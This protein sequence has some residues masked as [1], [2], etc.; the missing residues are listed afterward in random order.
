M[1]VL[2]PRFLARWAIVVAALS[3]SGCKEAEQVQADHAA[4][5]KRQAD[6]KV[7]FDGLEQKLMDLRKAVPPGATP[8]DSARRMTT[9]LQT[10]LEVLDHQLEVATKDF[11]AAD[12]ELNSLREQLG[13]MKKEL[14]R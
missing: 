13:Q 1:N 10:E 3:L 7:E 14:D 4:T 11:E 5:L 9:R 8:E 2:H 12:A 6:L